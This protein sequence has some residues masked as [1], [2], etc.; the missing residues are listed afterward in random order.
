MLKNMYECLISFTHEAPG[1]LGAARAFKMGLNETDD[2]VV[3]V[4]E[5]ATGKVFSVDLKSGEVVEEP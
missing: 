2:W 4:K 5:I 3:E 1:P